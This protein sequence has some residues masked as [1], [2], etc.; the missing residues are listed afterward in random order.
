[1]KC[2]D[3][4][5]QLC[6]YVDGALDGEQRAAVELHLADCEFCS[7]LVADSRAAVAFMERV[8]A[9]EVPRALV[10]KILFEVRAGGLAP[11]KESKRTWLSRWFEPV[12]QPKF[13]MGMA[14]TILSFA[15]L[16][17]FAG[18][19][20]RPMKAADL[21]PAKIWATVED[22]TWRTW[23]RARRYYESLRLGYEIRDTLSDWNEATDGKTGN[24]PTA[25]PETTNPE[26]QI[27]QPIQ[28]RL[29][30][31]KKSS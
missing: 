31:E 3:L 19:S 28:K 26:K 8:D 23:E 30:A 16:G 15:M 21:E 6:D 11:V 9:V 14:M 22:K 27:E 18:L 5:T 4:E 20:I 2:I 17:R 1:M 29:P 7:Q 13:A 12:L 25:A 24:K 10:N